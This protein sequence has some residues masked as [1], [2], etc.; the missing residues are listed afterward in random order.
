MQNA[1]EYQRAV[2]ELARLHVVENKSLHKM[3]SKVAVAHTTAILAHSF[4]EPTEDQLY[5]TAHAHN[6]FAGDDLTQELRGRYTAVC[7]L[8]LDVEAAVKSYR[9]ERH[10]P[11]T[12]RLLELVGKRYLTWMEA[13]PDCEDDLNDKMAE[14]TAFGDAERMASAYNSVMSRISSD[15]KTVIVAFN[16]YHE[17]IS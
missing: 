7:K 13:D 16:R 8:Q 11:A 10:H 14:L 1:E 17:R 6:P 12:F 2:A 5:E 9:E 15:S 4:R 3:V